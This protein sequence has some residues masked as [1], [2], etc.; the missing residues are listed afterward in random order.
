MMTSYLSAQECVDD[1]TGAYAGFGGCAMVMGA[2]GQ[3]CDDTF[4]GTLVADECPLSCDNCP[5]DCEANGVTS[6]G[7]CLPDLNLYIHFIKC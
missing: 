5:A 2:F 1:A 4:A 6:H 3:G 7:C